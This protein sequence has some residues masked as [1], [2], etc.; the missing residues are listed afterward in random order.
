MRAAA[1]VGVVAALL[2][3]ACS[4]PSEEEQ[5][6]DYCAAVSEASGELTRIADEGGAAAFIDALPTLEGLAEAA[7]GDLEDEW[8]TYLDALR[9]LR[10]ALTKAGLE[11]SA[12]DAPL[13]D[14]VPD[15]DRQAITEAV[16]VVTSVEVRGAATGIT[17]QALDVCDTQIL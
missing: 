11:P 5:R 8:A 7:P 4:E 2:L 14:E 6:A 15:A 9:G 17:Q 16:A 10:D 13:G 1:L 3:G 12:L